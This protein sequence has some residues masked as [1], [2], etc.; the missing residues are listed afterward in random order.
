MVLPRPSNVGILTSSVLVGALGLGATYFIQHPELLARIAPKTETLSEAASPAEPAP[1]P[2]AEEPPPSPPPPEP[3]EDQEADEEPAAKKRMPVGL[4]MKELAEMEANIKAAHAGW[5][6]YG[7]VQ[8]DYKKALPKLAA[9]AVL[10][11]RVVVDSDASEN[12]KRK[13]RLGALSIAFFA[14]EMEPKAINAFRILSSEVLKETTAQIDRARI[15]VLR[16]LIL[17]DYENPDEEQLLNQL[18]RFSREFDNP[19]DA[20]FLYKEVADKLHKHKC[21]ELS[22]TVLRQGIRLHRQD[23]SVVNRLIND[24]IARKGGVPSA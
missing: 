4:A 8:R 17:N 16:I 9:R 24:L 19:S 12:T 20:V 14:A 5:E 10:L 13:A 1:A 18:E 3:P 15:I 22:I 6:A 2:A 7:H 11:K 23:G 21:R